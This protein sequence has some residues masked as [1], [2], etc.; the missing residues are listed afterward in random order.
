M[1]ESLNTPKHP[2]EMTTEEAVSNLFHPEV[3]E[4]LKTVKDTKPKPR[5]KKE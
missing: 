5:L 1:S 4:H 2:R 3:V